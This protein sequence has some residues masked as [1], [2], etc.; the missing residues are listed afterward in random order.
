MEKISSNDPVKNEEVHRIKKERNILH[1][2]KRRK[3][4]WTGHIA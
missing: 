2:T 1:K 4:K 3:A